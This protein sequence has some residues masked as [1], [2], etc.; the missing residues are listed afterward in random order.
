[1]NLAVCKNRTMHT[2]VKMFGVNEI[3]YL[4]EKKKKKF[5]K[6]ALNYSRFVFH[7]NAVFYL[8]INQRIRG[9]MYEG[10]H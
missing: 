8:F 10:F 7:I 5:G 3:S 1:M 2:T 6:C 4:N 9:K